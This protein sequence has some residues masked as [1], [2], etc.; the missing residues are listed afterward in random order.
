MK[1]YIIT[2]ALPYANGNLHIGH[3]FEAV[4]ADIK[5]RYLKSQSIPLL[6]VSG[7]DSHGAATTLYCTKNNLDIKEH[8]ASQHL[9]HS[10]T[11]KKLKISFDNFSFTNN[12][13]HKQV[14]NWSIENVIGYEK[15]HNVTL[16]K[17]KEVLSWYDENTSQFLPDRYVVGQCPHCLALEQHPEIC[18]VCNLRILPEQLLNPTNNLSNNAVKLKLSLHLLLDT[19][20][21][22]DHLKQYQH[23]FHSSI[24][25]KIF[26][27]SLSE[28]EEIDISR[29]GPYYGIEVD[30]NYFPQ[31]NNQYYYVWFDAPIGYLSFSFNAWLQGKSPTKEL[32]LAYLENVELEHFI[33]KDIAYF[34]SFLWLNLLKII[35]N[36]ELAPV[37]Q[38]NFH[39]WLTLNNEKF[40]KRKGHKFNLE[41]LTSIEIDSLRLYF[42]SKYDGSIRD[43]EFVQ[44]EVVEIYNNVVVKNV[45]NFYARIIRLLNKASI[46]IEL[47]SIDQNESV[48]KNY[49]LEGNYKKLYELLCL[50]LAQLNSDF[51]IQQLWKIEDKDLLKDSATLLLNKWYN[52]YNIFVII[53]PSLDVYR[54][55]ILNNNFIH[56]AQ[57][58]ETFNLFEEIV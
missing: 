40:S 11:Y 9:H 13:L 38:I 57:R 34:H 18:E 29:D 17:T 36:K 27:G 32:F 43:T 5:V 50:E 47:N 58:L 23:L 51:Q 8:L 28:Q 52:I 26:D 1:N 7:D 35:T 20:L 15:N 54:E 53:L 49:L 25:N 37:K 3:F 6:F 22:Y 56:L 45:A 55:E 42:F 24:K 19:S 16:F 41:K 4:I 12:D 14:V 33:G 48:Y 46:T 2:T 44:K 31:L 39:G 21:F 30:K 10:Q